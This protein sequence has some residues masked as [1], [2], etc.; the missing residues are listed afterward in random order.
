M[1]QHIFPL[2]IPTP[3][4]V[5]DV[6]CYL[7]VDDKIV[8]VDCGYYAEES[9]ERL[10]AHLGEQGLQLGDLDEIWLTHGH[11]DHF[12]QAALLADRS[13]AVIY[14]HPKERSNFAGND[15][16][17]LFRD[18]FQSQDVPEELV[19]QMLD[20]L[21][22]LQQYQ[23]PIEPEWV[24]EGDLLESG[25][26]SVEVKKV[27]GHAPG[28]LLF[29]TREGVMF[30]GDLLLDNISTNAL[31]NFDPDTRQRN[32][33]LL[34]Y[35]ASLRW[36]AEREGQVLPGHGE[37]IHHI[38]EVAEH[39]LQEQ[40]KRYAH[41]HQLLAKQPMSL[42]ELARR[43][44]APSIEQGAVFLALSEVL[45]YL[46]WGREEETIGWNQRKRTYCKA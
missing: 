25:R 20:Q 29:D 18:Y 34:Q 4:A 12:G 1:S 17:D 46:D 21:E 2:R 19:Q 11:P 42:M 31:I 38:R 24:R 44:F 28:H 45:G 3:F 43:L 27:P 35:R 15:D 23:Q 10:K 5:G 14:G 8:L 22:W 30:G 26:I 16:R 32:K 36:I 6:F 33:S 40:E 7:I 13:G 37:I 41:I 39:H 9:L